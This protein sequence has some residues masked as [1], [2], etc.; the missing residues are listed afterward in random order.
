M[1]QID[2]QQKKKQTF[3][4][5][6]SCGELI[7]GVL[8]GREILISTPI[9]L[10]NYLTINQEE[11]VLWN[12][13]P[14]KMQQ[15]MVT[16]LRFLQIDVEMLDSL[17]FLHQTEIP[18]GV[19]M[20]SSTADLALACAGLAYFLG[21]SLS[22]AE[23]AKLMVQIEPTDSIIFP[24]ATLFEQKSAQLQQKIGPYPEMELLV[25]GL[26]ATL[27]TVE[28]HKKRLSV[29]MVDEE[30]RLMLEGF[31]DKNLRLIGK[32]ATLNSFQWQ[33]ILPKLGLKEIVD[34]SLSLGAYGVQVAHSGTVL[35]IMCDPMVVKFNE[36][37]SELKKAG[38]LESYPYFWSL[39]TVS[40]GVEV[41]VNGSFT[42]I[43][44]V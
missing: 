39:K 16:L 37:K 43:Y 1:N 23:L 10:Y 5:P 24:E 33:N 34:I 13:L 12:Q 4:M 44:L 22:S 6:G 40:G 32:A 21:L 9:N 31:S 26:N 3:R 42:K 8:N 2:L 38:V 41:F 17:R 14:K 20:A 29:P 28:F 18:V 25:L 35:G 15:G 11:G 7:Q 36:L 27:D 30:Y 19:G